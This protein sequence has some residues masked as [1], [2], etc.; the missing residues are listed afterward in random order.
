MADVCHKDAKVQRGRLRVKKIKGKSEFPLFTDAI[1][2]GIKN[3]IS[4]KI[5]NQYKK[6]F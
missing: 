3:S 1:S 4:N 6:I 2:D 5:L